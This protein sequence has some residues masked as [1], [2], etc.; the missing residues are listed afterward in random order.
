MEYYYLTLCEERAS[1]KD[2]SVKG[3]TRNVPFGGSG[4]LVDKL[5]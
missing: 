3:L 1:S 2:Y 4:D 5:L